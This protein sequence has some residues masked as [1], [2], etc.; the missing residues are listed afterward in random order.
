MAKRKKKVEKVK[1]SFVEWF[2]EMGYMKYVP[3]FAI[4]GLVNW[5]YW[6]NLSEMS[7]ANHWSILLLG[8]V[9]VGGSLIGLT[10]HMMQAFKAQREV[11]R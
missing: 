6:S 4:S 5:G 11:E 7:E 10:Y 8:G 3:S 2:K 1:L 9:I